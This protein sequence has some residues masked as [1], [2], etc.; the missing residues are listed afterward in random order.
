MS[1]Q[2]LSACHVDVPRYKCT[3]FKRLLFEAWI[4]THTSFKILFL[5]ITLVWPV[6]P[7]NNICFSLKAIKW[8]NYR[9]ELWVTPFSWIKPLKTTQKIML[10]YQ[11]QCLHLVHVFQIPYVITIFR[12]TT[13]P[14]CDIMLQTIHRCQPAVLPFVWQSLMTV[15]LYSHTMNPAN[16]MFRMYQPLCGTL[17]WGL[18]RKWLY[19]ERSGTK[20]IFLK[21]Q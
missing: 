14:Y 16:S 20:V 6:F 13:N 5:N 17:W 8:M 9:R 19:M 21:E 11:W 3:Q 2:A 10:A 15:H 7:L 18:W 12:W 1:P 4:N